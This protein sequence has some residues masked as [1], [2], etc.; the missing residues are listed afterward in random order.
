MMIA[1]FTDR[2]M[3]KKKWLFMQVANSS[4]LGQ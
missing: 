1:H 4:F 2:G 3:D